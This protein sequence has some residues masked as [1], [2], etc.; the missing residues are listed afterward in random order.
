MDIC[1]FLNLLHKKYSINLKVFNAIPV[2]TLAIFIV[3]CNLYA[4]LAIKMLFNKYYTIMLIYS[5]ILVFLY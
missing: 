5:T 3:V 4:F 1:N 2:R